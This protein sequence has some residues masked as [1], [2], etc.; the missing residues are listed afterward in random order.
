[1][2]GEETRQGPFPSSVILFFSS[3]NSHTRRRGSRSPR[4]RRMRI[5]EG[6]ALRTGAV[7]GVYR[8]R[9]GRGGGL[10]REGEEG[11]MEGWRGDAREGSKKGGRKGRMAEKEKGKEGRGE[12]REGWR[13]QNKRRVGREERK[14]A[15][16][17]EGN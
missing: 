12:G 11:G 15:E 14:E 4:G 9:R 3:R 17:G 1:M 5:L 2:R 13:E 16:S 10:G 8:E 6:G 7:I